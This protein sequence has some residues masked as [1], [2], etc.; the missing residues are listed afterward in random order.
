MLDLLFPVQLFDLS[1]WVVLYAVLKNV[2]G[3]QQR[4][5]FWR[6]ETG[7]YTWRKPTTTR[8]CLRASFL[9]HKGGKNTFLYS[10][11]FEK[12]YLISVLCVSIIWK[13]S[14]ES[15]VLV[16]NRGQSSAMIN[17]H[18]LRL[19]IETA[20]PCHM[21]YTVLGKY[22]NRLTTALWNAVRMA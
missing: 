12:E 11:H 14:S 9:K 16:Q 19:E 18:S 6:E 1:V 3:I 10:F 17:I 7:K 21:M 22:G 15:V 20:V 4:P 8:R 2:P 5:A 13:T